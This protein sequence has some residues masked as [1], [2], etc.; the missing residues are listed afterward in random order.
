MPQIGGV[1]RILIVVGVAM[2]VEIVEE[3]VMINT[4]AVIHYLNLYIWVI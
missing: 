4:T 2:L 1:E 3:H